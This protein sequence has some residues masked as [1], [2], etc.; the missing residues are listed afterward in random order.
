V[1]SR[2][3]FALA[4]TPSL[5]VVS[6]VVLLK[7]SAS[8]AGSS[9]IS[10]FWPWATSG[11]NNDDSIAVKNLLRMIEYFDPELL[12]FYRSFSIVPKSTE[13]VTEKPRS[14]LFVRFADVANCTGY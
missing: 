4:S 12:N 10:Q 5:S 7:S 2:L 1:P 9:I 13:F 14:V 11:K 8:L 6:I 3:Y